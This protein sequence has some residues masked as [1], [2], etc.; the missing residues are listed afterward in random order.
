MNG[1]ITDPRNPLLFKMF[2]LLDIGERAGSGQH[3]IRTVW[4]DMK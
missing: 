4:E 3:S 2:A 1:G